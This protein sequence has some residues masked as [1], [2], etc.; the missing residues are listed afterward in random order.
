MIGK[1]TMER[2]A[3]RQGFRT[4]AWF[5]VSMTIAS[6]RSR[7][8][9][10][11]GQCSTSMLMTLTCFAMPFAATNVNALPSEQDGE[12]LLAWWMRLLARHFARSSG[13]LCS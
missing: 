7:Q 2:P 5:S 13:A 3:G 1:T 10:W 8:R 4:D 12:S 11:R 9:R 6:S